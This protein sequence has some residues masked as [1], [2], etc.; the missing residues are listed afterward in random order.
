MGDFA[1]DHATKRPV[2]VGAEVDV[3][4]ISGASHRYV[5][6]DYAASTPALEGALDAVRRFLPYYSSVH[7]GAGYKSQISTAAY[8][9]ARERVLAFFDGRPHD[10]VIFT[11][12]TTDAVN[13]LAA[14]LPTGAS[15]VTFGSEHHANLLPWRRT[16]LHLTCL[17]IPS[18]SAEAVR[19][20]AEMLAELGGAD[21]VAVTGASNV[22]GELWPVAELATVAH[23]AGARILV[24]AAQT[25][26][27]LRVSLR[28]LDADYL[29]ASGHKM[30][31]PF[32]V[33]VIVGRGDWLAR[34]DPY[35]RGGGAV[36]FVTQSTV[37][38][39]A[40]PARQEAGSPNVVGAVALAAALAELSNYGMD[41]VWEEEQ[42]LAAYVRS[43]MAAI[44][45]LQI[46]ALWD[47]SAARTGVVPFNVEGYDHSLVAAA[48]SA[49]YGIGVRHGCFC[50]HPLMVELLNVSDDEVSSIR[51]RLAAG[52]HTSVPG[53]VRL[54]LGLGTT[55]DDLDYFLESLE[56]LT[57]K[58]PRGR[59]SVNPA[60]GDYEPQMDPRGV[61]AFALTFLSPQ[62]ALEQPAAS[63]A[64]TT[65]ATVDGIGDGDQGPVNTLAGSRRRVRH[66]GRH[67]RGE[68]DY[69]AAGTMA[70]FDLEEN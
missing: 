56:D 48:L 7:R 64:G 15:V 55:Q 6:L 65:A 22:T 43:G 14:S 62:T 58:G 33:G 26:P 23:A 70:R 9:G 40:L 17:P 61:A 67:Q 24:D 44:P 35:L 2:L 11:R 29:V 19:S 1:L 50:A 68:A 3:P 25:A 52:D 46:Y 45:G 18:T 32:G 47:D 16:N 36:D 54:S 21:L 10:F 8:E 38:W 53:A 12:N 49:E 39:A 20:L 60:T 28:S 34:G 66:I 59:Y 13:L 42:E 4:L 30:Y 57:R 63:Q 41:A 27:H 51:T 37:Q 5:N 69:S 31:A